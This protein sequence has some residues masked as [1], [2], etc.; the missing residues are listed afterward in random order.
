MTKEELFAI[1]ETKVELRP[2]YY[3]SEGFEIF[4]KN[5]GGFVGFVFLNLFISVVLSLIPL[6]GGIVSSVL[7]IL[8]SAGLIMVVRK[9]RNGETVLFNDFFDAFKNAGPPIAVSLMQ[10]LIIGLTV[11]PGVIVFFIFF[12]AEFTSGA[13]PSSSVFFTMIPL[14]FLM[15]IPAIILA[16]CYIFSMYIVLFLN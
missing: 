4:K 13:I 11:I 6:I 7:S 12:F 9:I 3:I 5:A 16:I 8:L 14:F 1:A 2:R 10:G 15:G